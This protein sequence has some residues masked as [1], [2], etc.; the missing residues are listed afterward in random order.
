MQ[1]LVADD[2]VAAALAETKATILTELVPERPGRLCPR[3]VTEPSSPYPS[4]HNQTDP[5]SQHTERTITFRR[6]AQAPPGTTDQPKPLRKPENQ[7]P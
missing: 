4:R 7:P 5:I 6:P 3:A 2:L 1:V